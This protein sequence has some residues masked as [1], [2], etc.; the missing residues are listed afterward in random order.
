MFFLFSRFL[1]SNREDYLE[2]VRL[3]PHVFEPSVIVR[4]WSVKFGLGYARNTFHPKECV[5]YFSVAGY[6]PV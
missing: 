5:N 3:L 4:R 6:D 1:D 2:H